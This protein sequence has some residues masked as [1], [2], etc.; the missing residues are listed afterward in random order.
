VVRADG[1]DKQLALAAL[2]GRHDEAR[3]PVVAEGDHVDAD[4]QATRVLGRDVVGVGCGMAV[5]LNATP[6]QLAY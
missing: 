1:A 3:P 2:Y 4:A 6:G 5:D